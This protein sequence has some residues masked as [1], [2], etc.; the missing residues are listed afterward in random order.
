[1]SCG[2]RVLKDKKSDDVS[3]TKGLI[4][5]KMMI[6]GTGATKLASRRINVNEVEVLELLTLF[7]RNEIR[8]RG[9][10]SCVLVG[11]FGLHTDLS[12]YLSI[13]VESEKMEAH[14]SEVKSI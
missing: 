9:A 6:W 1:M 7:V 4:N 12:V 2:L 13:A 8:F 5:L 3:D 14:H 10:C 11:P